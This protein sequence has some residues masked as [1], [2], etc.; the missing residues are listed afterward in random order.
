MK[1]NGAEFIPLKG[2]VWDY[3]DYETRGT[4]IAEVVNIEVVDEISF[5]DAMFQVEE[6]YF[7]FSKKEKDH[8]ITLLMASYKPSLMK[9]I[10]EELDK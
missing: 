3:W 7:I 10:L 6:E 2:D 1:D 4:N 8:L 5:K 9:R